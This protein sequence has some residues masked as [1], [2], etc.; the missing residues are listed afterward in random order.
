VFRRQIAEAQA[1]LERDSG[2]LCPR[3]GEPKQDEGLPRPGK[4]K[5]KV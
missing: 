5:G 1:Q 4:R 2:T 3:A